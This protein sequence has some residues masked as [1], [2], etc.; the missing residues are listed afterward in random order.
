MTAL[1]IAMAGYLAFGLTTGDYYEA[2]TKHSG[3]QVMHADGAVTLRLEETG[4]EETAEGC[5]KTVT[6]RMKD[7]RY[8]LEVTRHVRTWGDCAAIETWAE[9]RHDERAAIKLLRADSLAAPVSVKS[10]TV[11]VM[12]LTGI[13]KNEANVRFSEVEPGTTLDMVSSA[14]TRNAWES[15]AAMMV[16][17]GD[18]VDEENGKVLGVALEWPGTHQKRVRR[19]WNGSITE[20]FVGIDMTTGPYTLEPGGAVHDAKGDTRLVGEW[21]R[22]GVA[23]VPP[24]GSSPSDAAWL[25]FAPRP[26]Q[27]LGGFLLLVHGADLA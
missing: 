10:E 22:R 25:R 2:I 21:A 19:N 6:I 1:E 5:A 13:A 16:E 9:I 8:P 12:S 11:C 14:G 18:N 24:L 20:V 17:F 7:E 26:A 15:N 4:R 27:Q 3:L 23:W